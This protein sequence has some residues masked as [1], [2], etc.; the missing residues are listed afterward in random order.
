MVGHL[1]AISMQRPCDERWPEFD[2]DVLEVA[3][4]EGPAQMVDSRN[5]ALG[6]L[7]ACVEERTPLGL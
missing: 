2:A 1:V 3:L 4:A 6:A 7:R 5:A